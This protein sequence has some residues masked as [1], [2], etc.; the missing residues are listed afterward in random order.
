MDIASFKNF[1]ELQTGL[2][3]KK[4][5]AVEIVDLFLERINKYNKKL[6]AFLT[7]CDDAAYQKAKQIDRLINSEA[8]K[9]E[10]LAKYP[11][12]GI[13][14]AVK[15][16][17]LTE[18]IRTTA[19]SKVLESYV[20]AY[21]GTVI[22]RIEAAGA[23]ILGKTN[24]DAWGHGSS[25]ENSDFGST[26]NPWNLDYVPGGSSS[27]SA[28]AVAGDLAMAS[29]GTDTG[30]SVR[31]PASF[32]NLVGLKPTYGAVSRYGVIAMASSLDTVGQM[33]KTAGDNKKIFDC[34]KGEDG[35]DST[36]QIPNTKFPRS[37][38]SL[39]RGRQ[40]S[41]M[42]IGIPKEYFV[43]GVDREVG[44][45]I[46]AAIKIYQKLGF[47]IKEIS[48]PMTKYAISCYYI[49]MPAEVSSNL[50]RYDGVRFGENRNAF[51]DEAKRRIML[52]SYVLSAGYYDAYYLK[53]MTV[54]SKIINDFEKAF[55]PTHGVD[56][57]IAPVSPTPPFKIGERAENPLQ[58]YLSD[59]FTVSANLAGIPG[60]AV[61]AGIS[62][63]N[64]PIGFQL[65]GARFSEEKLYSLAE[66]YQENTSC[67]L[68]S[69][70]L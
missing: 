18:G 10:L 56:A 55:D 26:K 20:P 37:K 47:E 30:S 17:F 66:I 58:M 29:L 35:K 2:I 50:A 51:G 32:C 45:I 49:I 42:K 15:D 33:T 27:G 5:S 16:M 1:D 69:T 4:F 48:L 52:G 60:L 44:G 13:T 9:K 62:R 65:M 64:L 24:H 41:K 67:H 11:L 6:N 22:K 59:I 28:A 21:S 36:I 7:I 68:M 70:K 61:P 46:K 39:Q 34:I 54:R 43:K 40:N 12:L 8:D 23:I 53:A 31:L 63:N 57:I 25:G 38:A 19:A 14:F 3:T